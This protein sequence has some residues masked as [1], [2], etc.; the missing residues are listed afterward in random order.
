MQDRS[1]GT[2]PMFSRPLLP[3]GPYSSASL[4]PNLAANPLA[5]CASA[6]LLATCDASNHGAAILPLLPIKASTLAGTNEMRL[7]DLKGGALLVEISRTFVLGLLA[8]SQL[9]GQGWSYF[10][11][12]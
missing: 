2:K 6:V 7:T 8:T 11:P 10:R 1:F 4:T 9:E 3:T 12:V 5:L